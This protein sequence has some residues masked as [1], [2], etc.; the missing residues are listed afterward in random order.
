MLNIKK[1]I[2]LNIKKIIEDEI[3]YAIENLRGRT[4]FTRK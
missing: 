3:L 2:M 4:G 1:I